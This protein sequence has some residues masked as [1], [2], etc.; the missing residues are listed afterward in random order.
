MSIDKSNIFLL[1]CLV[2]VVAFAYFC[3][4]VGILFLYFLNFSM[5]L[6]PFL[7]DLPHHAFLIALVPGAVVIE[8]LH[9][10]ESFLEGS[11]RG[12]QFVGQTCGCV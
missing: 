5:F 1:F 7:F 2:L 3:D 11:E 10:C 9:H 6:S 4:F 8:F 12:D